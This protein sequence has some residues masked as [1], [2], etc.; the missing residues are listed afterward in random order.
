MSNFLGDNWIFLSGNTGEVQRLQEQQQQQ[1]NLY[2]CNSSGYSSQQQRHQPP[3]PPV[4]NRNLPGTPGSSSLSL[5]S[6][7]NRIELLLGVV[8]LFQIFYQDDK[9]VENAPVEVV[10]LS[11]ATLM[12][13]NR[14]VCEICNQGFP[15]D[16]NLQLHRRGHNLPGKLKQKTSTEIRKRVYICPEPRCDRHNPVNALRDL[17]GVK[18]HYGRKHAEKNLKCDECNNKYAVQ[19]DLKA[20]FKRCHANRRE[21]SITHRAFYDTLA[22]ENN[23]VNQ[24]LANNIDSNLQ[25][26]IPELM[27]AM[28]VTNTNT[29]TNTNPNPNT[30]DSIFDSKRNPLKSLPQDLVR[31]PFKRMT[32]GGSGSMFSSSSGGLFGGP[33]SNLSSSHP[34]SNINNPMMQQFGGGV[35][36]AGPALVPYVRPTT[37]T[38]IHAGIQQPNTSFDYY[39]PRTQ[40][41]IITPYRLMHR[42]PHEI[43]QFFHANSGTMPMTEMGISNGL[44]EGSRLEVVQGGGHHG[45]SVTF[46]DMLRMGRSRPS[47]L[48]DQQHQRLEVEALNQ[49]RMR[50]QVMN[51]FHQQLSHGDS[52]EGKSV[53]D[54]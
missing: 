35:P 2:A 31:M 23:T 1:K 15:R 22:E 5:Q 32:V 39:Q 13:T 46:L 50:M 42:H 29:N 26:Q 52:A 36:M 12:T 45:R 9:K 30:S 25:N 3:Q 51:P 34:C 16:Q 14:F 40:N 19:S 20:H 53:W 38:T 11:P 33:K 24:V 7:S 28:P 43:S 6:G 41:P 54:V 47:N 37:T 17:T 48:H 18:K 49:Q 21:S 4:N 44:I 10:A 27:S 8:K